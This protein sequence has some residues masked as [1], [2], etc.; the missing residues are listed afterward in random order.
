M[1]LT[2]LVQGAVAI[3]S[4]GMTRLG[5]TFLKTYFERAVTFF[6]V[7]VNEVAFV[8]NKYPLKIF[9]ASYVLCPVRNC[10]QVIEK[11]RKEVVVE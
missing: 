2:S 11:R 5:V 6:C 9:S 4:N 8:L 10:R 1:A 7:G 3:I